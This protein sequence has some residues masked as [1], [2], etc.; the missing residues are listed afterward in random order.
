MIV[1][2]RVGVM[3]MFICGMHLECCLT[4]SKQLQMLVIISEILIAI[5]VRYDSYLR[6]GR[7]GQ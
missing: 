7:C 5:S 4:H 6:G 1:V 3:T 2:L